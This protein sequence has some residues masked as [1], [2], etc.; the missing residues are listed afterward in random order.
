M[1]SFRDMTFCPF[2]ENCEAAEECS[3]P[4]TIAVA[5]KAK[6][7]GLPIAHFLSPPKCHEPR[8]GSVTVSGLPHGFNDATQN[9]HAA[10]TEISE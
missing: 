1:L 3:R 9:T 4:L 7:A 2:W 5:A 10:T 6:E 8:P